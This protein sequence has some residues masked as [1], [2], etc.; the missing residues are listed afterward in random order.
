MLGLRWDGVIEGEGLGHS[1]CF[2]D[3][4]G[5]MGRSRGHMNEHSV[6]DLFVCYQS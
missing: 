6:Q 5:F 1:K 2:S 4:A 3:I